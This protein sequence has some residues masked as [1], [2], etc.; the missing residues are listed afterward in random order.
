MI[1]SIKT[2]IKRGGKITYCPV[3]NSTIDRVKVNKR[4]EPRNKD[5]KIINENICKL[6]P[7]KYKCREI[8]IPLSWINGFESTK[9]KLLSDVKY[10]QILIQDYK[11]V[12]NELAE[13]QEHNKIDL[14]RIFDISNPKKRAIAIL[15]YIGKYKKKE[16]AK[17][18]HLSVSQICRIIK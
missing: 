3:I 8:C 4:R 7:N 10:Q 1:D 15:I 17:Y 5:A 2:Y 14:Q 16:I 12:I 13:D 6:C 11:E 18:F 9:E